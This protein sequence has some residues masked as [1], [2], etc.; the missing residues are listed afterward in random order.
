MAG[1]VAVRR[2]PRQRPRRRHQLLRVLLHLPGGRAGV[3]RLRLRPAGPPRP[4]AGG[5]RQPRSSTSRA[6]S[7]TPQHPNGIIPR[8]GAGHRRA[9]RRPGWSSLGA[10]VLAGLGWIGAMRDGIR[11]VFGVEGAPG[12]IVTNKLRDLGVLVTIGLGSRSRPSSPA[13]SAEPRAGWPTTSGWATTAGWSRWPGSS[14]A[15][16]STPGLMIL[17]LRFLSGVPLP[18]RRPGAGRA[19]RRGGLHRPEAAR[20]PT[21]QRHDVQPAVRLDRRR[22]RAAGLAQPDRPAHV[23][24]RRWAAN[25]VGSARGAAGVPVGA[26]DDHRSPSRRPASLPTFGARAADRT[27]LAAGAVLGA[28]GAMAVGSLVRGVAGVFSARPLTAGLLPTRPV[29]VTARRAGGLT[30]PPPSVDPGRPGCAVDSP[31]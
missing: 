15:S 10:L 30:G 2:R 28:T 20:R 13:P 9:H 16:P 27:T 18:T 19:A 29:K 26:V 7:R 12:N 23:A 3:H 6:S 4:A 31:G 14:S 21:G 8:R 11:A 24:L 5:R 17:L 25:D 1:V 22:R